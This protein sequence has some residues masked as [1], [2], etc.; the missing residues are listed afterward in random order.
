MLSV[1]P[2]HYRVTLVNPVSAASTHQRWRFFF[3]GE[4]STSAVFETAREGV[5][6]RV[7]SYTQEGISILKRLQAGRHSSGYDGGRFSPYHETTTHHFQKLIAQALV[8]DLS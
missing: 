4:E 1:T 3:V 2:D 8:G 5:A 6:H 7:D